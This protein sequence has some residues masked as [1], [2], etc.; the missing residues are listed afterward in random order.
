MT[1]KRPLI[2][3]VYLVAG[4]PGRKVVLTIG[5]PRP[6]RSDWACLVRVEGIPDLPKAREL[7]PGIDPLQALQLALVQA[8]RMLDASGLP[9]LLRGEGDPPGDV[10]IPLPAP[11]TH[12]FEFQR[13]MERYME[14]ESKRFDEAL[15]AFF[16]EGERR[17]AAKKA[18]RERSRK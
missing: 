15:A 2:E 7:V 16:R 9:F 13:R 5:R 12:G 6:W 18:T 4:E 14:R 8:R 3:R 10:G 1:A 11:T 17:R